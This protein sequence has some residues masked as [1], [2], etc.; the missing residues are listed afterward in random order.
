MTTYQATFTTD[1]SIKDVTKVYSDYL[2]NKK[3]VVKYFH[4]DGSQ[5]SFVVRSLTS[6]ISYS[7]KLGRTGK[8]TEYHLEVYVQE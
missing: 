4:E 3:N 5:A 7:A 1:Q 6:Q 8:G 2:I